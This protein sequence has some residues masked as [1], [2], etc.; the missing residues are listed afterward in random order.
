MTVTYKEYAELKVKFI[1][2]HEKYDWRVETS[3]LNEYGEYYKYYIFNDGAVWYEKMSPVYRMVHFKQEVEKII[4]H[5][6]YEIKLLEVEFFNTDNAESKKYY[7][8]W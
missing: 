7:E 3:A 5:K 8:Q 2:K 4:V 6:I 1:K